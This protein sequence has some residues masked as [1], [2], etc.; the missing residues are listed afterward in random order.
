MFTFKLNK[1]VKLGQYDEKYGQRY[2]CD[3]DAEEK[4]VSFNSQNQN[5]KEGDTIEAEESLNKMS[6]KGTHYLMLRKVKVVDNTAQPMG[7]ASYKQ[8]FGVEMSVAEETMTTMHNL[9]AI[10]TRVEAKLDL[11]LGEPDV[12]PAS[13]AKNAP[14]APTKPVH[15]WDKVAKDG[16]DEPRG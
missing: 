16:E 6:T 1:V 12:E 9:E 8:V 15:N 3:A 7:Q 14:E 5:I 11:L 13:D 10:L 4:P 2:W